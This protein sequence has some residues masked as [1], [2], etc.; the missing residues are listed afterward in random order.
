M[1]LDVLQVVAHCNLSRA[2]FPVAYPHAKEDVFAS[3]VHGHRSKLL[4]DLID[5][6]R[7]HVWVNVGDLSVIDIP[8]DHTLFSIY[9]LV[10]NTVIVQ[11]QFEAYLFQIQVEQLIP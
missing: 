10:C 3:S 8:C 9:D 2:V 6:F 1:P 4:L 11:V 5:N 7:H